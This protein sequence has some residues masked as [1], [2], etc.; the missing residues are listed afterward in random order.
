MINNGLFESMREAYSKTTTLNA[1][2]IAAIGAFCAYADAQ[3]KE[4]NVVGIAY[5]LDGIA[6]RFA[7]GSTQLIEGAVSGPIGSAPVQVSGGVEKINARADFTVSPSF[8]ITGK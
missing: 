1:D 6:L 2:A 3:L 4:K 5:A 7:D 8:L